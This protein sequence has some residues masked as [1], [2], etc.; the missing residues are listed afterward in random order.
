MCAAEKGDA[1]QHGSCVRSSHFHGRVLE[2]ICGGVAAQARANGLKMPFWR[3]TRR[4]LATG[5]TIAFLAYPTSLKDHAT[6][7]LCI[8]RAC[9]GHLHILA[10]LQVMQDLVFGHTTKVRNVMIRTI[11]NWLFQVIGLLMLT[12]PCSCWFTTDDGSRCIDEV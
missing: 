8:V 3:R 4:S 1:A 9:H 2:T 10:G 5:T 7:D 12:A 11:G 6:A